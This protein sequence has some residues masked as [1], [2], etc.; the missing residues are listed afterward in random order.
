MNKE[1]RDVIKDL[2]QEFIDKLF[3]ALDHPE[4]RDTNRG[5]PELPFYM[6]VKP[7]FS[8][9]IRNAAG[10]KIEH[11]IESGDYIQV[12]QGPMQNVEGIVF[13]VRP[14][15]PNATPTLGSGYTKDGYFKIGAPGG[16]V[17]W[18]EN[19]LKIIHGFPAPYSPSGVAGLY[20]RDNK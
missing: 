20:D 2:A 10:T 6:Q 17:N 3:L 9:K 14:V 13:S 8:V 7:G 4:F 16:F 15:Y 5:F 19:M 18:D 11:L 12:I 1:E